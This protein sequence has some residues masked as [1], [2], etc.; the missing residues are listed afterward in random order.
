M[1]TGLSGGWS[2]LNGKSSEDP[3]PAEVLRN[4]LEQGH[5][6][7]HKAVKELKIILQSEPIYEIRF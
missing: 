1:T 4:L 6:E 5:L 3:N 7:V 2:A